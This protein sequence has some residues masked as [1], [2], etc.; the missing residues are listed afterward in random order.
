MSLTVNLIAQDVRG[1]CPMCAA[2]ILVAEG[3]E[4]SEILTCP[5]CQSKLV[6]D[7]LQAQSLVLSEAPVI[8]EDWG[9]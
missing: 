9:G 4:E 2:E 8:E 5:E 1:E 7:R 3:T 6:V